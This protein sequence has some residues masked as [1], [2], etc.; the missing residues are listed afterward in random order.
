MTSTTTVYNQSS[1]GS[2]GYQ[3]EALHHYAEKLVANKPPQRLA[4]GTVTYKTK[5]LGCIN[6][7]AFNTEIA[8]GVQETQAQLSPYLYPC[9]IEYSLMCLTVFYILW[10]SIEQR[11]NVNNNFGT[12]GG[13]S[14]GGSVDSNN[15]NSELYERRV[16]IQESRIPR[17]IS[18]GTDL[19][20]NASNSLLRSNERG[21][22]ERDNSHQ[23]RMVHQFIVGKKI[24]YLILSKSLLYLK[25]CTLLEIHNNY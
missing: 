21:I 8:A 15:H 18:V 10:S 5:Q 16:Q 3:A 12:W 2:T 6:S 23:K 19:H 17:E 14:V 7:L 9:I 11:Y 1:H 24:S 22:E 25:K 4:N 13:S 20:R